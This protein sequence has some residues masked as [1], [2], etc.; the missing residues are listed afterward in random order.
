MVALL[1][2]EVPGFCRDLRA[3]FEIDEAHFAV[4]VE[5]ALSGVQDVEDDD[6][7]VA[8]AKVFE[9][10]EQAVRVVEEVGDDDD[11][12]AAHD[13]FCQFVKGSGQIG[14]GAFGAGVLK[15]GEQ[16]VQMAGD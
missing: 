14:I 16:G 11:E 4:E 12:A 2:C 5:V 8:M 6:F 1:G 13:A 15:C 10:V 9:A 3:G 7:V